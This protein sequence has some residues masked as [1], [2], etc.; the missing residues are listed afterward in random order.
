MNEKRIMICKLFISVEFILPIVCC[1]ISWRLRR[2][3]WG[4]ADGAEGIM[5]FCRTRIGCSPVSGCILKKALRRTCPVVGRRT[6]KVHI[7]KLDSSD[8]FPCERGL[9]DADCVPWRGVRHRLPKC[10][11]YGSSSGD[12][13]N[14]EYPF[15]AITLWSTLTRNG[16]SC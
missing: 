10:I 4:N 6:N 8:Y 14:V 12:L 3:H 5:E 7:C 9:A 15:T 13:G 16:C 11:R 1:F 2:P